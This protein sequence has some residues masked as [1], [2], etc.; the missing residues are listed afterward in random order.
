MVGQNNFEPQVN[1]IFVNFEI[2][3]FNLST[4]YILKKRI[5]CVGFMVTNLVNLSRK[6]EI[7]ELTK[8]ENLSSYDYVQ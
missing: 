2:C 5:H 6:E 1:V 3:N 4:S 8:Y 7:N